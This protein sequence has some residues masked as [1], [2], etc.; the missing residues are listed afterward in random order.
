MAH[1]VQHR[2]CDVKHLCTSPVKHESRWNISKTGRNKLK[3][4]DC[5]SKFVFI[6]CLLLLILLVRFRVGFS[7]TTLLFLN[8]MSASSAAKRSRSNVILQ[9]CY[10]R[11]VFPMRKIQVE[12]NTYC[13][14]IGLHHHF[15]HCDHNMK[16]WKAG[17]LT[18]LCPFDILFYSF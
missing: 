2:T 10:H 4:H 6:S 1:L 8:L 13:N 5:F 15:W 11:H 16:E 17:T 9:R 3:W 14:K 7:V 12:K 18:V